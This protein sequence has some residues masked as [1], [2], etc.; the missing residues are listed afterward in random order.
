MATVLEVKLSAGLAA[1]AGR[2]WSVVGNFNG[3]PDW[4]PF[5]TKSVLETADGGVGRRVSIVGGTGEPRELVERLTFYDAAQRQF[6]YAIIAGPAPFKNY[7]GNF[8]ISPDGPGRC[9][10]DY[11]SAFEAAEGATGHDAIARVSTFYEAAKQ[12]LIRMFGP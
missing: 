2:V 10:F 7:V 4:H 6:A 5:V 8:R 12:H 11:W 3:M 9:V 1:P